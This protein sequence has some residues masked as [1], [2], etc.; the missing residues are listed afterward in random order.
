VCFSLP[1]REIVLCRFGWVHWILEILVVGVSHQVMDPSWLKT[2]MTVGL[3][4]AC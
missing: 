2:V 3:R 1:G 4:Q